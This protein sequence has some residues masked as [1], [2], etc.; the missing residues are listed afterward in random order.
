MKVLLA[1]VV[2]VVIGILASAA[3]GTN[4]VNYIGHDQVAAKLAK[5]GQMVSGGTYTVSGSHRDEAGQVEMH[6]KETDIFYV[7]DGTATF[8]TGGTMIGG[9]Q[10]APNQHL[11]T[12]LQGGETH[13]LTKG[14]VMTIP[15]GTNH[16]FKAVP[17]HINYF[18]V[19]V[20]QP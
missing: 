2:G 10:S 7:T 19:K 16:W 17:D 14:D 9:K 13:M 18:V 12:D 1:L 15:A 5:G 11:G 6:D 8:V 3:V 4:A 20:I